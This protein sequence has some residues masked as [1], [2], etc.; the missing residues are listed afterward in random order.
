[1]SR[2]LGYIRNEGTIFPGY[3]FSGVMR[4]AYLTKSSATGRSSVLDDA[5]A[6]LEAILDNA[7]ASI[8]LMDERQCCI[9]MNRAAEALT[10]WSIQEIQQQDKPLHDIIHYKHPDGRPF[11]ISECEIDRAFPE[12]NRMSGEEVFVRRDGGFIDV[13]FTASP[14]KDGDITVGTVVEVRD[15]SNEKAGAERQKLLLDELNHRVKNTLA[16]VQSISLQTLRGVDND[17]VEF[18]KRFQSR[19]LSLSKAHDLLTTSQWRGAL[20]GDIIA[21]TLAPYV[22]SKGSSIIMC[23]DAVH[24][25]ANAAVTLNMVFHEL[26]T[27]AGKYGSLS[28]ADGHLEITWGSHETGVKIDWRESGGPAVAPPTRRGFG[29]RMIEAGPRTELW[30]ETNLMFDPDGVRCTIDVPFTAKVTRK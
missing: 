13:S 10:G 30:A 18:R 27:N 9:Y 23:G 29:T 16:T 28:V 19:L 8:F 25:T 5:S 3:R 24:L 12:S 7:T 17:P 22:S 4:E 20:L 26:A 2:W 21:L 15:I 1:L 11:P 6:R 14:I